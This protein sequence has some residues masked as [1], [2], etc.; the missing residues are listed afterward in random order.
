MAFMFSS[1]GGRRCLPLRASRLA[2]PD[3]RTTSPGRYFARSDQLAV[4]TAF[5]LPLDLASGAREHSGVLV[6]RRK[7]GRKEGTRRL[8]V[9]AIR[10]C[11]RNC[12]RRVRVQI[13]HWATGKAGRRQRPASQETCQRS[14]P[15]GG[16]GVHTE[17]LFAAVTSCRCECREVTEITPRLPQANV[18]RRSASQRLRAFASDLVSPTRSSLDDGRERRSLSWGLHQYAVSPAHWPSP[19]PSRE[20]SPPPRRHSRPFRFPE[21]T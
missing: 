14:H 8:H 19:P 18:G 21:L 20:S 11:P 12:K 13:G 6:P 3:C 10:G 7:P 16:R 2:D 5:D 15:T 1:G 9:A 4:W 17:R